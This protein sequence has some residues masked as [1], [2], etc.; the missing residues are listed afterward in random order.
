MIK[1]A[2]LIPIGNSLGLRLP[3]AMIFR[4]GFGEKVTIEERPNGILIRARE[5]GKLS[6]ENT[7]K[8]MV[9]EEPDEWSDWQVMDPDKD[10]HLNKKERT[11]P[12]N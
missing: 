12:L 11:F 5:T 4:Y 7:Y 2:N 3:K 6:W 1:E 8:A 10:A 9:R